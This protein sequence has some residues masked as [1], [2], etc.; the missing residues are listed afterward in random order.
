MARDSEIRLRAGALK[1]P[2]ILMQAISHIAPA[3]GLVLT[4]QFIT[5]IA[6]ITAP[7]AYALAVVIVWMLGVSLAQLA[8]HLPSAGG[9]Y[10]YI[11]RT[12]H[13]RAGFLTAWLYLLYDPAGTAI[14]IAFMGFFF[15]RTMQ[16][17]FHV[18]FPWWLFVIVSTVLLTIV[19]YRGIAPSA[20]AVVFLGS[21]EIL[22]VIGL[23]VSGVLHPGAGG[24]NFKPYL[25]SSS[26]GVRGLCLGVVFSIFSV[27]GF[28]GVVPLAEESENP[29]KNIPRAILASILCTGVFY[30]FCSWAVLVG[31]GTNDITGFV[32][33]R[34]NACFVLARRF[35]GSGWI[36][37]LV[38]VLNS[39]FAVSIACTNAATRVFFALGR[40]GVFPRALGRVHP[41]HRTPAN[42]IWLQTALT[43]AVGLGL[44]FWIG[45]DQEFYFMGL[46][47]TLGLV[48]I[49][50]VSN[51]GVFRFY[52]GEKRSEFRLWP[53]F[54]CPLLS[55]VALV[56]VGWESVAPL[57]EAPLRYAPLLIV[58]WIAAG[59]LL[60]WIM[61]RSGK[62]EWL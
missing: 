37:L 32:N 7:L 59:L 9:Y 30:L 54:I 43:L 31:W 42:A 51:W 1:F 5:S 3:I 61:R 47:I 35:W 27:S 60:L 25:L 50:G 44:G 41:Q 19:A 6:G 52:R 40:S 2:A 57:P 22:I 56:V 26:P 15:E 58:V 38:A 29:R 55:T 48:L 28:D 11:S 36:L 23:S 14:N 17:Q 49:Y 18:R 20:A 13:P 39:V 53:H 62:E 24:I 16:A 33:S 8:K 21:A 12:I 10:T 4:I 45:P 46:V 34:E